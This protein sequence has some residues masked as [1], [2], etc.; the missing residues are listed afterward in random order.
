MLAPDSCDDTSITFS[1]RG[2]QV[3]NQGG[4]IPRKH[5]QLGISQVYFRCEGYI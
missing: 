2:H 3:W 1:L 4:L 5:V